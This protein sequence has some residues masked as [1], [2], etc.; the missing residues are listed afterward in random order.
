MS[1][2]DINYC[3]T[4]SLFIKYTNLAHKILLEPTWSF[5]HTAQSCWL[6]TR[7]NTWF[8]RITAGRNRM[9][10]RLCEPDKRK[11]EVLYRDFKTASDREKQFKH[12]LMFFKA[13]W[14]SNRRCNIRLSHIIE[15]PE[16]N[17]RNCTLRVICFTDGVKG[18]HIW[19]KL[20][21]LLKYILDFFFLNK[22]NP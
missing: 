5:L 14:C 11:T 7:R 4:A 9:K 8:Y 6:C 3:D 17:S 10:V 19:E 22:K 2:L 12:R 21:L 13:F 16:N 20:F 1:I 18:K 15:T